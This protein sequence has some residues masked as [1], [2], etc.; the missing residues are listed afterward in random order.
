MTATATAPLGV[1][2]HEGATYLVLDARVGK[3]GS[4]YMMIEGARGALF[5]VVYHGDGFRV[6]VAAMGKRG[7]SVRSR[8]WPMNVGKLRTLRAADVKPFTLNAA[9]F[10]DAQ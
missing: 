8:P 6:G 4:V 5:S 2:T 10:A 3:S 9:P 7:Q 1:L